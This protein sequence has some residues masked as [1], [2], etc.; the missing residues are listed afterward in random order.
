MKTIRLGGEA[1]TFP[2]SKGSER[3]ES[4]VG[5]PF[6]E[7]LNRFLQRK[8]SKTGWRSGILTK[9]DL[10][11][12]GGETLPKPFISLYNAMKE[13]G[14]VETP[15]EAETLL[16]RLA[17]KDPSIGAGKRAGGFRYWSVGIPT[18]G[19]DF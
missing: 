19:E 17:E 4:Y 5:E 3:L 11:K 12:P 16:E 18:G 9:G 6:P 15:K 14:F 1:T 7:F 13:A 8:E 10:R 2:L